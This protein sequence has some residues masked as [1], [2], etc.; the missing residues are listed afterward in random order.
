M[1]RKAVSRERSVSPSEHAALQKGYREVIKGHVEKD[2][3]AKRNE[4]LFAPPGVLN[5]PLKAL[6]NDQ[7][8]AEIM[9]LLFNIVA[10]T[11]PGAIALF[12]LPASH[13]L[14]ALFLVPNQVYFLPR[15]ILGM[16]YSA[17]RSLFD[18]K[19]GGAPLNYLPTHL[20]CVFF[21]VP[22]GMYKLHHTVMHHTENNLFPYDISSTEPYQRDNV[23]HFLHY[24]LKYM[25]AAWAELPYYAF[26]RGRYALGAQCITSAT[27]YLCSIYWMYSYKPVQTLWVFILPFCITSLALMLGNWSQH[28]FVD[29]KKPDSNYGLTYNC[30]DVVDNQ[31]SF[32]D[33]YHI[34][35]HLNSKTHWTEMPQRFLDTID[36]HAEEDAIIIQGMPALEVAV[37]LFLGKYESVTDRWLDLS[38]PAYTREEKV[39]ILK[40]R[41]RPIVRARTP[42]SKADVKP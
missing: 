14:G 36:K 28:M 8:D 25:I 22:S 12:L 16:H 7:R 9:Y 21:G 1:C 40:D 3:N 10:L 15:F 24:L 39:C 17:H 26:R 23:M 4:Y 11:I 5:R 2:I 38:S 37:R 19:R 6:M 20:I 32:N 27:A 31:F 33:G 18:K 13:L 41:L 34:V 42:S 29:P 30:V 35:H